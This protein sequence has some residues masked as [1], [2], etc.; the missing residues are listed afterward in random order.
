MLIS[1][2]VSIMY[3]FMKVATFTHLNFKEITK[4]KIVYNR[5]KKTAKIGNGWRTFAQS[6]KLQA[7]T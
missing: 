3:S 2:L 7:G 6:Q 5:W 4:C 1:G